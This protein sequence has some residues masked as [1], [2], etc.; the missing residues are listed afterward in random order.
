MY[1]AHCGAPLEEGASFCAQCAAPIDR[2]TSTQSAEEAVSSEKRKEDSAPDDEPTA[3]APETPSSVD[4]NKTPVKPVAGASPKAPATLSTPMKVGLG[5][6]CAALIISIG[7]V[8]AANMGAF[9]ASL[10]DTGATSGLF[11]DGPSEEQILSDLDL[12]SAAST[13]SYEGDWY[14]PQEPT[15][16]HT[17]ELELTYDEA[18]MK[19]YTV[20]AVYES[21]DLT[22]ESTVMVDY[23][24][25]DGAWVVVDFLETSRCVSPKTAPSEAVVI[26]HAPSL[27]QIADE[28][29]PTYDSDDNAL[30]L[31]D[32]YR[33]NFQPTIESTE[34]YIDD[35]DAYATINIAATDGFTS[36]RGQI[37]ATLEWTGTDWEIVDCHATEG[38][39]KADYS[40]LIGTWVGEYVEDSSSSF[41]CY[42]GRYTPA[43]MTIQSVDAL[44]KTAR[45]DFTILVHDHKPGA[46]DNPVESY[47]GDEVVAVE[48][49]LVN[50]DIDSDHLGD[51]RGEQPCDFRIELD[52]KSGISV[53][54][55][56]FYS[57]ANMFTY[58][59]DAFVMKKESGN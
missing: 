57:D 37:K 30:E 44:S 29:H 24:K 42:A 8:T 14:A 11:Y 47:S 13:L 43:R 56:S 25:I 39:Y 17:S 50:L 35:G 46:S 12:E 15:L 48:N 54:V 28:S 52:R 23:E 49:A 7:I 36:Y 41:N 18:D 19:E 9:N 4:A 20:T 26:V 53:T 34:F 10:S 59:H 55:Y 33:D 51:Y 1:C 2:D 32:L 38:A 5:I 21:D 16:S 27:M 31:T 3:P 58:P 6:G 45:I 40:S 22:T